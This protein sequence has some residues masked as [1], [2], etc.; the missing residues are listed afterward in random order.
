M[1]RPAVLEE[2]VTELLP[3]AAAPIGPGPAD[4][5]LAP[6]IVSEEERVRV[7]PDGTVVRRS[8]RVEQ[9][10]VRRRRSDEIGW[11]LL[12]LLVLAAIALGL[13]WYFAHRETAK[14]TVP[15]VVGQPVAAAV[16]TLQARGLKT[17]I[18]TVTHAGRPGIVFAQRPSQGTR[19]KKG[20]TVALQVS[21][22]PATVA[23]PNAVGLTDATA[24]DRLVAAGFRVTEARVFAK[25]QSG[26][27]VAQSPAAGSRL[28]RGASVRINV[29]KGPGVAVVPVVVDLTLGEAESRLASAGFKPVVQLRVPSAK[30]AG[31]VVAQSP[32]GGQAKLGSRVALNVSD[33]TGATPTTPTATTGAT[34]PTGS[35]GTGGTP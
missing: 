22:R 25:A 4:D 27:V 19:V 24:R 16:N 29:S 34:G 12:V 20:S 30:P 6:G 11:A 3:T 5:V 21:G 28:G 14:R 10:P 13:W 31:T 26:M 33:G 7:D 1:R 32:P 15:R 17:R 35:T 2:E 9:P 23:V 8:D 18:S